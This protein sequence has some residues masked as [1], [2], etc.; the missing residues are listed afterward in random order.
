VLKLNPENLEKQTELKGEV[1]DSSLAKD[2]KFALTTSE[3]NEN[4]E[5][6]AKAK[7]EIKVSRQAA[8]AL[9]N[10]LVSID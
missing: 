1:M 8:A 10:P 7:D 5:T 2:A 6:K 9:L 4:Q 3:E